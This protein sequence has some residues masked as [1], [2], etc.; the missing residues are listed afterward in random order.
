M[1]G[2]YTN[3]KLPNLKNRN[4]LTN[5]NLK[6]CSFST[7]GIVPENQISA[8]TVTSAIWLDEGGHPSHRQRVIVCSIGDVRT[9]DNF[10]FIL[11][12]YPN[13]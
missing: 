2:F 7:K 10:P 1:P 5:I 13:V 9:L 8:G 11:F 3:E 6:S 4:K 12:L